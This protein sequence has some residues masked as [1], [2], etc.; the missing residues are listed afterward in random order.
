[1]DVKNI[2]NLCTIF[3]KITDEVPYSGKL[4]FIMTGEIMGGEKYGGI[5]SKPPIFPGHNFTC[6]ICFAKICQHY[7]Q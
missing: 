5:S 3:A 6:G 7:D 1:M 2:L 4:C